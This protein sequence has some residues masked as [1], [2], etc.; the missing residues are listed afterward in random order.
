MKFL[1]VGVIASSTVDFSECFGFTYQETSVVRY[2]AGNT[3]GGDKNHTEFM[4]GGHVH[5]QGSLECARELAEMFSI[6]TLVE[7]W[8]DHFVQTDGNVSGTQVQMTAAG[9]RWQK[10][11]VDQSS[12]KWR[13]RRLG[14]IKLWVS[15]VN[16]KVV[17][18]GRVKE[19]EVGN[20]PATRVFGQPMQF[21]LELTEHGEVIF[22]STAVGEINELAR[23]FVVQTSER[24]VLER[25]GALAAIRRIDI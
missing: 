10:G 7:S 11:R 2:S 14:S 12:R 1:S 4:R 9:H 13:T 8:D 17:H 16:Y 22:H 20:L 21:Y 15:V 3:G 19:Q 5:L 25:R 6:R 18:V 23:R 24:E